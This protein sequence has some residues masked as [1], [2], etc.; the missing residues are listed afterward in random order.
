MVP[1][2]QAISDPGG[3]SW[4]VRSIIFGLLHAIAPGHF[5]KADRGKERPNF[6]RHAHTSG[7]GWHQH[8]IFGLT[9]HSTSAFTVIPGPASYA[10]RRANV[11]RC[12]HGIIAAANPKSLPKPA[13]CRQC[14]ESFDTDK[15]TQLIAGMRFET[16]KSSVSQCRANRSF[17]GKDGGLGSCHSYQMN[18]FDTSTLCPPRFT[19]PYLIYACGKT[20]VLKNLRHF[21]DTADTVEGTGMSRQVSPR[22]LGGIRLGYSARFIS[23]KG[24]RPGWSSNSLFDNTG[25]H[26]LLVITWR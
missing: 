7:V 9:S 25:I 18:G 6:P 11:V 10:G 5:R 14:R 4:L 2:T 22:W 13:Q 23:R 19:K 21:V 26:S 3:I 15:L 24:L 8:H 16:Q 20:T 12:C 1:R 17:H